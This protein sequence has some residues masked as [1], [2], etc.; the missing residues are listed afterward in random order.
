LLIGWGWGVTHRNPLIVDVLRDRNALFRSAAEGR[1]ENDYTL[2]LVNKTQAAQTYTVRV[3]A[4]DGIVL[5]D[6][7]QRTQAGAEEVLS[8]PLTLSAPAGVR[9]KRPL[10]FVVETADGRLRRE[11]E[12]N[13]FAPTGP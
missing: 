2:K 1:T 7:P 3:I 11:I 4:A 12:A 13:F 5:R 9:G 6:G 8:L 10:R